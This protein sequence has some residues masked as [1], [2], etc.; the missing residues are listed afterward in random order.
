MSDY[1]KLLIQRRQIE[2]WLNEYQCVSECPSN[3]SEYFIQ[4]WHQG[5]SM[6]H[7]NFL[8]DYG[9]QLDAFSRYMTSSWLELVVNCGLTFLISCV[10][11]ILLKFIPEA[12]VFVVPIILA[13]VLFLISFV[14]LIFSF[15]SPNN[16]IESSLILYVGFYVIFMMVFVKRIILVARIFEETTKAMISVPW[17]VVLS[18]V[19]SI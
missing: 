10:I 5:D 18:I 6:N 19:V 16:S 13:A 3:I 2:A 7:L 1:P 9:R 15:D 12:I 14:K 4:C 11:L 8:S 17:I